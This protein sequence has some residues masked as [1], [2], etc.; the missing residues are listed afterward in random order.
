M[1]T[2]EVHLSRRS[3]KRDAD[4]KVIEGTLSLFTGRCGHQWVG[5][6]GGFFG[7]PLC[8]DADGDHHL[9]SMDSIAV[10]PEDWGS[11]WEGLDKVGTK[12][13]AAKARSE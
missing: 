11:A 12:L 13:W 6:T 8:G 7:C 2:R 3:V 1:S 4:K 10:Q 9:V 5:A